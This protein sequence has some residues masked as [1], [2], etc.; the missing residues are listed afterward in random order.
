MREFY[1]LLT[2]D[3]QRRPWSD[4]LGRLYRQIDAARKASADEG[5][6]RRLDHLTLYVRHAELYA[7]HAAGA[8]SKDEVLRH[9]W[10]IR[11]TMMVHSYGLWC[12]L[13]GQGAALKDG[14]PLKDA[15]PVTAEEIAGILAKGIEKNL[16]VDPG[17]AGVEYGR[18]LVPATPL[19]LAPRPPGRFPGSS[20]DHQLYWLW[21]ERGPVELQATVQ[22]VWANRMPKLTLYSPLEVTLDPVAVDE[23]PKPDGKTYAVSMKTPHAG[24]HRLETLD[25]GDHTRLAFPS[26]MPVTLESGMDGR[27]VASQFRG[28]WTLH[29]YVPKGT[30]VVGGWASR[31]ANWAPRIS[32]RLKDPSGA[33]ALDFGT[34]E[35]GWFKAPVPEGRD[36][37]LWTFEDC[38]GQR[39]LMTVPPYLA[40][41]AEELLLPAEVVEADGR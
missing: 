30:K 16:P 36:G 21:V 26:G 20:Q 38:Q 34:M 31:I 8:G 41:T 28:A 39:L 24:L 19:K 29:F 1:R 37:A 5:V 10:R 6:R 9:A 11:E 32:G 17:F 35:E 15:T 25:G 33:V 22:K 40:R 4:L 18:T 27:H 12:R 23:T 13:A 7:S 14:H 2:E 3:A